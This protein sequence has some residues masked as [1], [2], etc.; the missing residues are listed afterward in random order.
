MVFSILRTIQAWSAPRHG[1]R[2]TRAVWRRIHGELR[3]RGEGR[4]E[5]GAFLLGTRQNGRRLILDAV[6]YDDVAPGAL[7]SGAILVP[8]HAY[9]K[10]WDE[11]RRRGLEVV[12][13]VHTH[14]RAA[15]QSSIDSKHPMI[16]ERGHVAFIIPFFAMGSPMSSELGM[17]EYQGGGSWHDYS[18]PFAKR[19]FLRTV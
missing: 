19:F 3:V 6:Y 9:A 7:R 15:Y 10:L 14:P 11:C 12:A 16:S 8:G 2:C 4:R 5:S 1:I 13:D 17:Y 18:G